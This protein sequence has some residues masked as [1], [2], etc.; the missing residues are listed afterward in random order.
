MVS[1]STQPASKTVASAAKV[2][3]IRAFMAGHS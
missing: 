3:E 2:I 1:F